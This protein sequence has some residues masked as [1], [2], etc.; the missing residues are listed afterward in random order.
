MGRNINSK[1]QI[2]VNRNNYSNKG[3]NLKKKSLKN[4]E[5]IETSEQVKPVP[6]TDNLYVSGKKKFKVI[7]PNNRDP[8]WGWHNGKYQPLNR[9]VYWRDGKWEYYDYITSD[10]E[11]IK[12]KFKNGRPRNLH[13]RGSKNKIKKLRKKHIRQK[14]DRKR[15]KNKSKIATPYGECCVCLESKE[16]SKTNTI[17][18][19]DVPHVLCADCKYKIKDNKCPLC[20]SH[21]INFPAGI[22]GMGKTYYILHLTNL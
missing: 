10:H 2:S 14:P 19:G 5:K 20:R 16:M 6:K 7:V 18:C 9:M 12:E 3:D 22:G 17:N 8:L 4:K 15:L 1:S 11:K 13:K 21:S